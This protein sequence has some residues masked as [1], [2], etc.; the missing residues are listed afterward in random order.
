MPN[1]INTNDQIEEETSYDFIKWLILNT[2]KCSTKKFHF[3]ID[4]VEI[5]DHLRFYGNMK[6]TFELVR[7][8]MAYLEL[9]KHEDVL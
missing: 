5:N 6:K 3:T 9:C 4:N 2:D 1:Y 7:D 8:F